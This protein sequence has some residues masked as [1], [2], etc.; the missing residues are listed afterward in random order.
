[1]NFLSGEN[2]KKDK[3]SKKEQT[4]AEEHAKRFIY[5]YR[6]LPI[7]DKYLLVDFRPEKYAPYMDYQDVNKKNEW[8]INKKFLKNYWIVIYG[9][10]YS[11]LQITRYNERA[12]F[13]GIDTIILEEIHYF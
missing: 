9:K 6:N 4:S 8:Q 3:G 1:L 10:D 2:C 11:T 12:E 5:K 13:D 7:G